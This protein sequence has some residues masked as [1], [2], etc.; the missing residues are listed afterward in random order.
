MR[1]IV[2]YLLLALLTFISY[3][4]YSQ[5]HS[6]LYLKVDSIIRYQL[7]FNVDSAKLGQR[8][9]ETHTANFPAIAFDNGTLADSSKLERYTLAQVRIKK[10]FTCKELEKPDVYQDPPCCGGIIILSYKHFKKHSKLPS[11]KS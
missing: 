2:Q 5:H 6:D 9:N 4:A 11:S 7:K 10:V 8:M 3:G 1:H